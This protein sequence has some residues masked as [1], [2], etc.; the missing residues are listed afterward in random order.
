MIGEKLEPGRYRWWV[1]GAS[2]KALDHTP[3]YLP[4]KQDGWF[5]FLW[6]WLSPHLKATICMF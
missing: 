6:F 3:H 1:L 2:S 4:S 5:I